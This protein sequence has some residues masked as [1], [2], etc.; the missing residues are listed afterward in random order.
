MELASHSKPQITQSDC[1][2]CVNPLES[3]SPKADATKDPYDVFPYPGFPYPQT[4]PDRLAVMGILH[5][6]SPAPVTSCRVLEIGCNQGANLIPMAYAIPAGEFVGFDAARLPIERG[7]ARIRELALKNI[8]LFAADL[9]GV[10]SDLGRFDYIIAHGFYAW[11]PEPVRDR[12][13]ALCGQLLAPHGVAF[14]SY[15]AMP[16]GHVRLMLRDMMLYRAAGIEDLAQGETEALHFLHWLAE[17]RLQDDIYRSLIEAQL[18]RMERRKPGGTY[19]D[20]MSAVY[21]PIYFS[22]F[23]QHAQQHGLQYL[24]E[25]VL[26]PP[27]DPCYHA[28]TLSAV[29]TQA[30]EDIV[31]QEQLLDFLRIRMYRE[32]LLC[33]ADL[34]LRRDFP[35]ECFR[36]LRFASQAA[37]APAETPDAR[38]FTLPGT[39]KMESNHPVV[40]ALLEELAKRWPAAMTLD[41]LAPRLAATGMTPDTP[42]VAL[43]V[44]L[45]VSKMIELR[46]WKAP[47]AE[48]I[49]ERPR[50]SACGRQEARILGHATTLLHLTMTLEDPKVHAL[51]ELLDGTRNRDHLLTAM[52]SAFPDAP[53]S[54]LEEGIERSLRSLH[55][56]AILEA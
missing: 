11:V 18:Q 24:S 12:L 8:Q 36:K 53:V 14:V 33:R 47:L 1:K 32:T 23:V 29:Q 43:L 55:S 44:R 2:I 3:L 50:A 46:A 56:T 7:Q 19:H 49:A 25:A 13:L 21:H 35:A 51:L 38:V 22:Q 39:I 48:T 27:N 42:D 45:A 10:G 37:S 26:P 5:G 54:D 28:E 17:A 9:L 41:E 15:N 31:Q 6:M 4:H 16:G 52:K 20:E 30:G 34:A 40:I